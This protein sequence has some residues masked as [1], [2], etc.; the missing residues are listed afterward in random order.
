MSLLPLA[1]A[2]YLGVFSI[3]L[4]SCC[5]L[6]GE[7]VSEGRIGAI[8]KGLLLT[9]LVVRMVERRA[10]VH[11]S[12][13]Q[14]WPISSHK[15]PAF[16]PKGAA[17][18]LI[19]LSALALLL[20]VAAEVAYE[21]GFFYGAIAVMCVCVILVCRSHLRP[22][23]RRVSKCESRYRWAGVFCVSL[24]LTLMVGV[25]PLVQ[26]LGQI[27]LLAIAWWLQSR[28]ERE[29]SGEIVRC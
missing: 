20:L 19:V 11:C 8:G 16:F 10:N 17:G 18:S 26:L 13:A 15:G 14:D 12:G 28:V 21:E 4:S 22:H 2:A 9:A 29:S 7:N 23:G 6:D 5:L 3:D 25:E 1:H 24:S 27:L